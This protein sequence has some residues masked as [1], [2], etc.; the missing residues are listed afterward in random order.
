[1]FVIYSMMTWCCHDGKMY[2]DGVEL[3]PAGLYGRQGYRAH[4]YEYEGNSTLHSQYLL[5]W[6]NFGCFCVSLLTQPDSEQHIHGSIISESLQ[7]R[8]Y[9][10]KHLR[11]LWQH[12]RNNLGLIE[13]FRALFIRNALDR[14][15][16]V[17]I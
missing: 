7:L 1:M 3:S 4:A 16:K 11:A 5:L 14:F 2:N 15:F 10:M 17:Q 13:E 8:H 6:C 12:I 9:C